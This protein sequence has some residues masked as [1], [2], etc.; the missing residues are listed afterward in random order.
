MRH[1]ECDNHPVLPLKPRITVTP[2]YVRG[3]DGTFIKE[4][5]AYRAEKVAHYGAHDVK[6]LLRDEGIVRNRLKIAAR[7][8]TRLP[9]VR[10]LSAP[11]MYR[12][13]I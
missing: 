8:R 12:L 10:V 1:R 5:Q 7:S 11:R 13:L 2:R 3:F 4:V 6:R 9:V